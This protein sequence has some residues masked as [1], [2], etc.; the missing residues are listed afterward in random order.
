M[1]QLAGYETRKPG[2][3]SGGQQQR[4]ALARALVLRPARAAA[5]RAARRARRTAAQ[6]PA[7]RAE[8]AAGRARRDVRVRHPRPGR[9]AHDERPGRGH[10]RAVASSR[11]ARRSRSTRSPA[12]LFVADF[13]GVSNLLSAD[14]SA[15]DANGVALKIGERTLQAQQ[16]AM[17][18]RGPVKAMIRPERVVVE[19]QDGAGP[20]RLPGMVEHSVF[21]GSFRELHVRLVGGDLV[22]AVMPNDG[23]PLAHE[24]GSPV[25]VHLP[26]RRAARAAAR[27]L[28]YPRIPSSERADATS[29]GRS[30]TRRRAASRARASSPS[31]CTSAG[32]R[33][34]G[35]SARACGTCHPARPP[36][37]TTTTSARRSCSS[38]STG[39]GRVRTPDGWGPLERGAVLAI[40]DRR[41]R[42][43]PGR[44]RRA[45]DARLPGRSRRPARRT[46]ASTPTRARSARS[47]A[48][49]TAAASGSSTAARTRSATGRGSSPR[50]V[51]TPRGSRRGREAPPT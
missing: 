34:R 45:G 10:E 20:N 49:R 30:S 5:G 25:T 21:L 33:A 29:S 14:C 22:K 23:S 17:E 12:T 18:M 32:A 6:G 4:V 47:S 46:S 9:G 31:A 26:A 1:V 7:G 37:P 3:L 13:L 28:P 42:R 40:R 36:T 11:R 50:P 38:C 44:L 39:A 51:L 24:Q 41:G 48:A 8:D 15:G 43:A 19:A 27:R 2:Q 35:V 16:G